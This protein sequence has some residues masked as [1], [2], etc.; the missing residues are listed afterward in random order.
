MKL[1]M[2]MTLDGL[3]R[4]LRSKAHE[5]AEELEEQYASGHEHQGSAKA[6]GVRRRERGG[7]HELGRV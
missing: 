5:M 6:D 2:Q 3:L 4:A 7:S 1:A